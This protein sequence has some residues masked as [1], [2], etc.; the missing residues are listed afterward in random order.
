M[1]KALLSVLVLTSTFFAVAAVAAG[2]LGQESVSLVVKQ[3]QSAR[4]FHLA[5]AVRYINA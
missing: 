3:A 4:I 5:L 1:S 2:G